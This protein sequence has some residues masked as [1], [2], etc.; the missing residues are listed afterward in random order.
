MVRAN[1]FFSGT[2]QGVGFRFTTQRLARELKIH[3]WVKNL[4]D[5]RVEMMAEGPRERL[6]N[7][8]YKIDRHYGEKITHKDIEWLQPLPKA[9]EFFPDRGQFSEFKVTY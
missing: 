3:G 1:V 5:G 7:L 9:K 2:V 6:E 8:L 4:P